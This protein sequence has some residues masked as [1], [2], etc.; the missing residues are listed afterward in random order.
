MKIILFSKNKHKVKEIESIFHNIHQD[1]SNDSNNSPLDV[2][3]YSEFVEPFDVIESGNTF[4]DNA[5]LKLKALQERLPKSLINEAILISEDSGICVK[6]INN[7]PGIYSSRYANILDFSNK[8]SIL[9]AKDADDRANINRLI[10]DLKNLHLELSS[11]YF[12]S[13][14]A[15]WKNGNFLTTHGFLHGKVVIYQDGTSGFGYDPIF[16]PN[17]YT[18]SLATLNSEVK[19]SISHRFKAL[20]LMKILLK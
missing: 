20:N 6:S 12:I 15:A 1:S 18:K 2:R 13:C 4:R 7:L 11:A 10:N 17:G 19:N 16:I 9:N 14:V 5:I 3:V 8:D